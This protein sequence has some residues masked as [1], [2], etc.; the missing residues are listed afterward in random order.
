MFLLEML[1]RRELWAA[2]AQGLKPGFLLAVYGPA[3]VV[4]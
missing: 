1:I 3:E 4:P 2:K